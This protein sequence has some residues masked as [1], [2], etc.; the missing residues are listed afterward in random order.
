MILERKS[1][2]ASHEFSLRQAPEFF[3]ALHVRTCHLTAT[4]CAPIFSTNDHLWGFG[5]GGVIFVFS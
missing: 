5:A 1:L 4:R 3:D 2:V